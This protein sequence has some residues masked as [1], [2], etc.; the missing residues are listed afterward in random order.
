MLP[1]NCIPVGEGQYVQSDPSVDC[2]DPRYRSW[3]GLLVFILVVNVIASPIALLVLLFRY[4]TQIA[5]GDEDLRHRL[6]VMYEGFGPHAFFWQ[7][8]ILARRALLSAIAVISEAS[9]RFMS[10]TIACLCFCVIHVAFHPYKSAFSNR[11]EDVALVLHVVL[12]SLLGGYPVSLPL[13]VQVIVF[14]IVLLPTLGMAGVV[15]YKSWRGGEAHKADTNPPEPSKL[16]QMH[17]L[18]KLNVDPDPA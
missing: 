16:V 17:S 13:A 11:L 10:F 7:V 3:L 15:G 12:S 14:L 4:R 2:S 9:V 1:Q 5:N 18:N 8:V 6:G